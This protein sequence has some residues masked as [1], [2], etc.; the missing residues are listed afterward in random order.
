MDARVRKNFKNSGFGLVALLV[1]LV[2]VAILAIMNW[3]KVK[4]WG[5]RA[6]EKRE[7][8]EQQIEKFK[9]DAKEIE[10]KMKDHLDEG[11]NPND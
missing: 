7:N 5:D 1:V 2:V 9:E 11:L 6:S 4:T 3:D 8:A 10:E